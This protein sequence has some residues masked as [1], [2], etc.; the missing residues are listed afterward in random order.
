MSYVRTSTDRWTRLSMLLSAMERAVIA[1]ARL[2]AYDR[3]ACRTD[4]E[5]VLGFGHRLR[6][7]DDR[8]DREIDRLTA[9]RLTADIARL[10]F[11]ERGEVPD[12]VAAVPEDADA[13]A[14]LR[15]PLASS[16]CV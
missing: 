2:D 11:I 10:R 3:R 9:E 14:P 5:Q 8:V 16:V 1:A 13:S 15:V 4:H 6:L 12:L 7:L